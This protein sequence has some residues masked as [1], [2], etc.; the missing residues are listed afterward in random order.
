MNRYLSSL[1]GERKDL[2]L[3]LISQGVPEA[4]A[5]YAAR[6]WSRN[7]PMGDLLKQYPPADTALPSRPASGTAARGTPRRR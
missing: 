5:V 3:R 7:V 1:Y 6:L 2:A 4:E